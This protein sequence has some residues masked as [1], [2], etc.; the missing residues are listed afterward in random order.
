MMWLMAWLTLSP[1]HAELPAEAREAWSELSKVERL[2]ADF[3]Q[4]QHRAVL[5][6]P[7]TA[8]GSIAFSRA[9]GQL[10]WEVKTPMQSVFVMNGTKVGQAVPALGSRMEV[11]LESQPEWA[12]LV[13]ALTVWLAGDLERL[14]RD[15]DVTWQQGVARLVPRTAPLD[16]LVAHMDLTVSGGHVEKMV[17]VEPSGDRM[18]MRLENVQ[19]NPT[20]PAGTFELP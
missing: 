8:T 3:V 7:L 5:A 17:W 10:R 18:E 12:R 1:A 2:Q 19:Q 6:K 16:G 4:L 11:D 14:E 13:E 15:Y 20:L 9:E